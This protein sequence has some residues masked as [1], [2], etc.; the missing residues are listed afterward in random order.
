MKNHYI[1]EFFSNT[2]NGGKTEGIYRLPQNT[3]ITRK[4]KEATHKENRDHLNACQLCA[5]SINVSYKTIQ[6]FFLMHSICRRHS[7]ALRVV[8]K[9]V[10]AAK[11]LTSDTHHITRLKSW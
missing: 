5:F 1:N 8:S 2:F 4:I 7:H 3:L 9:C 10:R 6:S 11:T